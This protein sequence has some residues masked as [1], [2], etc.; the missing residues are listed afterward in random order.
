[1]KIDLS[2]VDMDVQ[3]IC[4]MTNKEASGV[5]VT[6]KDENGVGE[7][8]ISYRKWWEILRFKKGPKREEPKGAPEA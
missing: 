6:F 8:F 2:I 7:R 5:I 4:S 1:M 3:G